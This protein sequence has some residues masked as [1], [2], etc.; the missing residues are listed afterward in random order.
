MSDACRDVSRSEEIQRRGYNLP[1]VIG[2]QVRELSLT[3]SESTVSALTKAGDRRRATKRTKI[4]NQRNMAR[5]PGRRSGRQACRPSVEFP[6]SR[7]RRVGVDE[8]KATRYATA[9]PPQ[10]APIPTQ[11][12][13]GI[14]GV[15][16]CSCR[17]DIPQECQG[18]GDFSA[19]VA[20]AILGSHNQTQDFEHLRCTSL[21]TVAGT[22]EMP[23]PA[24]SRA[25][26]AAH[27]PF[28]FSADRQGFRRRDR[29]IVMWFTGPLSTVH[30]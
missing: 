7:Q 10:A 4:V 13:D 26:C 30:A 27:H 12:A 21:R 23:R 14:A 29:P 15:R 16:R 24:S 1:V 18:L 20:S 6:G 22:S 2:E 3:T 17:V 8:L 19:G 5:R 9:W 28:H 25:R 11:I